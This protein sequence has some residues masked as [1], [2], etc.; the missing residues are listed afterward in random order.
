VLWWSGLGWGVMYTAFMVALT[1]TTVANVLI[2]EALSP[3]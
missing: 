2:T 1:L 3:C